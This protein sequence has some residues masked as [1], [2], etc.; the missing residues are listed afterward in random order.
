MYSMNIV[1]QI[2]ALERPAVLMTV[3]LPGSGKTT[4]VEKIEGE[5]R[6]TGIVLGVICPDDIRDE[7]A[8]AGKRQARYDP[9]INGDVFRVAGERTKAVL[10]VG[11]LVIIDATNL[12]RDARSSF[13]PIAVQ[14]YRDLGASTVA[15][16]VLDVPLEIA[17]ARNEAR[18]SKGY[19][20]P[21]DIAKMDAY[22]HAH[23]LSPEAPGEFDAVI[24]VPYQP[25]TILQI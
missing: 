6:P 17:L 3:A 16:L 24:V 4:L 19:V 25:S 2:T 20:E 12:S 1:E 11:G 8:S 23:P 21:T 5:L 14:A 9:A 15:A 7:L 10:G 22:R 13:R 18:G